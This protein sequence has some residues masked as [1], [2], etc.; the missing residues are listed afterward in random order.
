MQVKEDD[1]NTPGW[2]R[3]YIYDQFPIDT[4]EVN[5]WDPWDKKGFVFQHPP[6][7]NAQLWVE[8]AAKESMNGI[9]SVLLL[10][11]NFNS[12]YWRDVVYKYAVEI[13]ILTCPIKKPGAKKQ[14]VS[15]MALVIFQPKKEEEEIGVF[16]VEP[17]GWQQ[18]YYKRAR[19]L[20]RFA[21]NSLIN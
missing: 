8:K 13:R 16:L 14:I 5:L 2:L 20:A 15:Q 12:I 10:P 19:N 11:A 3:Q 6:H 9:T 7:E 21:G 1:E 17:E 4:E 18:N